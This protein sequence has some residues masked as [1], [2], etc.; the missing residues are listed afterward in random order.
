MLVHEV[1][2]RKGK[3][4]FS[5]AHKAT[6]RQALELMAR[7]DVGALLVMRGQF[8]VGVFS[9]RDYARNA[10]MAGEDLLQNPVRDYM[11]D[12][13]YVVGPDEDVHTCLGLMNECHIRHLPVVK[14]EEIMGLV[15][16]G[17]LVKVLLPEGDDD[18]K[19]ERFIFVR[20]D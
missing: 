19:V 13:V 14:D 12:W 2:K 15:S 16:I 18:L 5:I 4:V 1:L 10:A 17:D 3:D 7:K 20:P 6:V 8:L 9:E 11:T